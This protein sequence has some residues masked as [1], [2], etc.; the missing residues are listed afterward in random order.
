MGAVKENEMIENL[1]NMKKQ[2]AELASVL[3]TF[4]SEAV[5]LRLLEYIMGEQSAE[6]SI[7]RPGRIRASK[8]SN[9][10]IKTKTRLTAKKRGKSQSRM[11]GHATVTHLLSTAFFDKP[12]TISDITK[13]CKQKFAS[14]LKPSD[15][16][17]RLGQLAAKGVLER[18]K[19]AKNKYA[20]KKP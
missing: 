3:N 15:F 4:K 6:E 7:G 16:S 11:G 12:R 10:P 9:A 1:K 14:N 17:G 19:N 20:Y 5:Q 13:Y 18:K 2:L 8:K